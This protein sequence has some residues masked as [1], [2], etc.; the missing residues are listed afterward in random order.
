MKEASLHYLWNY[1]LF[2]KSNLKSTDSE[3]ISILNQGNLNSD[4]GPDFKYSKIKI[5]HIIWS[6]SVEI[7]I[8]SSDWYKHKHQ[9][10]KAYDSVILHVVWENDKDVFRTNKTK[11]PCL[12]LKNIVGEYQVNKIPELIYSKEEIPCENIL[13]TNAKELFRKELEK[14]FGQRI[15]KKATHVLELYE[16]SKSWENV[17]YI[18]LFRAMGTNKNKE[19]FEFL[20]KILPFKLVSKYA[21]QKH[22]IEALLFG[23]AGMLE[24]DYPENH[25][26]SMLK[27]NYSF[28]SHKHSLYDKKMNKEQWQFFRMHA[29]NFPT[30]RIAQLA[31]ILEK[32]PLIFSMILDG[33]SIKE[34]AEYLS[35]KPSLY[36]ESNFLFSE[37][38]N[39]DKKRQNKIGKSMI[40]GIIINA[41]VPVLVAY[42]KEAEL[43]SFYHKAIE[44]LESLASEKNHIT[45]K[46]KELGAEAKNAKESQAMI[47]LYQAGCSQKKCLE[48]AV[49]K[50]IIRKK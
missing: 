7:H 16:R 24:E 44:L 39:L 40:H 38:D 37:R 45:R 15:E 33:K 35:V 50:Q 3:E 46:L 17:A 23:L 29:K 8:Q 6:G 31:S 22:Y 5:G 1:L 10:D 13:P 34:Y 49:G 12:E 25:Y 14:N 32:T 41:I 27:R 20:A 48:C 9:T 18:L 2:E 11:I 43:E 28:L 36:W 19:E 30:L 4:S 42:S 21:D 47:E 26:Y